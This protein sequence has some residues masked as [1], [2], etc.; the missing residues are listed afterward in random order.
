LRPALT[1]LPKELER[2]K[3]LQ[4]LDLYSNQ[5]TILPNE[6]GQLQNLEELDLGANQLRTRLKTLGM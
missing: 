6:I 2:F 5:L 3:N 4:K 1:V